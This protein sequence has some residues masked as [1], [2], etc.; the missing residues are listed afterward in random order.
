[1]T[2]WTQFS[3]FLTTTYPI[4]GH[5]KPFYFLCNCF[6]K[7]RFDCTTG[8]LYQERNNFLEVA[9]LQAKS[10]DISCAVIYFYETFEI[11]DFGQLR[12]YEF[13]ALFISTFE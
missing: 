6:P 12:V 9:L 2:T 10:L 11:G 13:L 4:C 8:L 5:S 1:M 7:S 3:P